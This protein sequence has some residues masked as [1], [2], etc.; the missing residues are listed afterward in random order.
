MRK[1][2]LGSRSSRLALAQAEYLQARLRAAFPEVEFDIVRISTQGD[3]NR[4]V[5]MGE[6]PGVGF[7]VKE[8]ESALA[9]GEAD[10]AVHS[11]K[12][13]PVELPPE[14]I[15]AAVPER[16][17]TRDVLISRGRKL[18]QLP[19]GAVVGSDSLRR[20]FQIR[21]RRPDVEVRSI[22]GNIETRIKAVEE[23]R[24]DAVILAAAGLHRLGLETRIDEYLPLTE[25]LPPPGQAALGIEVR[26]NDDFSRETAGAV[27]HP[28]TCLAVTAERSF[29]RR[30]GGG[31][32]API[33]ALGTVEGDVLTLRGMV[34]DEA[35]RNIISRSLSGTASAAEA[36]GEA[37]AEMILEAGANKYIN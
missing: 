27:N 4:L 9:A 16:E 25:F 24:V 3:R 26:K 1:I 22:R 35:G 30:L 17:D 36:V 37:L 34:A 20:S 12:D 31:C 5:S 21:A 11:L 7:F 14:F 6:L 2:R 32:R 15:L 8:I 10:I 23:G 33:A 18:D 13:V 29:L 28:P 19:V